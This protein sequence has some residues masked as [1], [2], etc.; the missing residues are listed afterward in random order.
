[1][2]L[3]LHFP[4]FSMPGGPAAF[5]P[6]LAATARAADEGGFATMTV[7]DHWFQMKPLGG[8]AE[9]ML[10]AYT[11]LGFLAAV[12]ERI[13]LG[14]LVTGVTYRYPGL[15]AK[16]VATL[17]V[18]SGGR[19]MLGIGAAWYEEEHEAYGVPFP[20]LGERFERL[21]EALEVCEQM[22]SNDDGPYEGRHF[23]LGA[24]I[25]N[26]RPLASPRPRVL[27]GGGG[28][29]KTLRLVAEHGDACNL[30][31]LGPDVVAHKL[32]VLREHC[33]ALGRD[34]G[35]I[36]KTLTTSGEDAEQDSF[37]Q[38]MQVYAGLG[39]DQ[40]W[41]RAQLPDP[42]GTTARLAERV[43]PRLAEL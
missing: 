27:I 25:C 34:Y 4:N 21:T 30:F 16:T 29:R 41:I 20:P 3:A 33:D 28:E 36:Q 37:L 26:P 15:L 13:E 1:M 5:A 40:V 24:T 43:L 8:S 18:L 39:I 10:E 2:K 17:D 19:A 31:D 12:T 14:A 35:A 9:P 22:W 38:R 6:T 42:A 11:T 32:D 7:M 23:Q